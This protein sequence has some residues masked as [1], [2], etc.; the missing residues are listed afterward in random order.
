MGGISGSASFKAYPSLNS[1][2]GELSSQYEFDNAI[3]FLKD[4]VEQGFLETYAHELGHA[5]G[6]SHIFEYG[7]LFESY[8]G[9]TDNLMDYDY[10]T[11]NAI[12]K[13]K[14][15]VNILTKYQIDN[16]RLNQRM[17]GILW[18]WV[19]KESNY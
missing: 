11:S 10:T 9:Y 13:F 19:G 16:I 15:R 2:K 17:T 18:I 5:L 6:L 1:F 3:V 12:S 8:Q 14:N 4:G 7:E